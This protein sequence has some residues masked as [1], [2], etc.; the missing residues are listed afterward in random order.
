MKKESVALLVRQKVAFKHQ[1][2]FHGFRYKSQEE[3]NVFELSFIDGH[4]NSLFKWE[5]TR[6]FFQKDDVQSL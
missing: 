4:L 2:H 6:P 1:R 5:K 3:I